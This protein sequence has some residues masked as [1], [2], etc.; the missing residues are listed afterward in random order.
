MALEEKLYQY[1]DRLKARYPLVAFIVDVIEVYLDRR[2]SRSSAELAYYLLLSVFPM[3]IMVIS[4]LGW[5]HLEANAVISF[6]NSVLPA[7]IMELFSDYITYVLTHQ[8]S[9]LFLAGLL[10]SI[11]ASSAGFRSLMSISAEIYGRRT[12]RGVWYL[13][14]SL[15]FSVLLLVMVYGS[16]AVVLTGNWFFKWFRMQFSMLP[17]P[18]NLRWMRLM[19]LF[20]VALL[21]LALL[22][23]VTAPWS[24]QRPPVLKGAFLI[25]ILLAAASGLFSM[26]I[27]LSTRYS[28]VYGSLA[29]VIILML[30]LYLCGNI[31]NLGNVLN[32]VWW[33]RKQGLPVRFLLEKQL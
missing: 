15:I 31:V 9:G 25:S 5:L 4:A 27:S 6:L 20:G 30:W 10:M 11:T 16:I 19:I 33:R 1:L 12:F 8:S 32:Y 23:R 3:L 14:T 26:F 28:T 29:S 18:K 24:H 17:L 2:V 21:V 22:Y 7:Q 13:L